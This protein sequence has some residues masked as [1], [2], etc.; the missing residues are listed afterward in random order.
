MTSK[1]GSANE[2]ATTYGMPRREA[3]SRGRQHMYLLG[4]AMEAEEKAKKQFEQTPSISGL[5]NLRKQNKKTSAIA[6]STDKISRKLSA[7]KPRPYGS[8]KGFN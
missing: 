3:I 4:K 8:Q 2:A 1:Q 6:K 7:T 5:L